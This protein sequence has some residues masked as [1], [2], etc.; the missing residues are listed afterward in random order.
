MTP[1]EREIRYES[2]RDLEFADEIRRMPGC[3]LIDRCIQCATCSGICPLSAYMDQTPRRI[4]Q[5]ARS[6][7]KQD[8]LNCNTIWLCTSCYQCQVECP[9][10]I[11]ITDVMYALKT[12]ALEEGIHPKRFAPPV[13]YKEFYKMVKGKGRITESHLIERLLLNANPLAAWGMKWLGLKLVRTKRISLRGEKMERPSALHTS[14]KALKPID[15][16]RKP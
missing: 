12:K 3:E 13:L 6:G 16:K 9:K 2:D 10:E 7:F 11:G 4:I 5:L 8:V 1:I 15:G 14:L